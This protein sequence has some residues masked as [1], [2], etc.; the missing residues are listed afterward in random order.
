MVLHPGSAGPPLLPVS[1]LR[2][3]AR[4]K[5]AG[6]VDDA[7]SAARLCEARLQALT[8]Q[9]Q[10]PP[11]P[12]GTKH[13]FLSSLAHGVLDVAGLV[14]VVGEPADG[15]NALWYEAQGDHLN[16][17]LSAAGMVPILGWGEPPA[18]KQASKEPKRPRKQRKESTPQAMSAARRLQR[19]QNAGSA[20]NLA[21]LAL[22]WPMTVLV[23]CLEA[24]RQY[25]RGQILW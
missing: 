15:V 6:A 13:G 20:R 18:P 24:H 7:G 25:R 21:L 4:D 16:P 10:A 2:G 9:Q 14:P 19:L 17:T 5:A 12:A 8:P 1:P 11:P 22:T 23:Q 3:I